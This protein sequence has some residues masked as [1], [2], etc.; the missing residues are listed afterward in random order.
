MTRSGPDSSD[1]PKISEL[2]RGVIDAGTSARRLQVL[3]GDA[4]AHQQFTLIAKGQVKGW[5]KSPGAVDGLARALGIDARAVVL[6]F[7]AELGIEVRESRSLLAAQLPAEA[8]HLS[9]EQTTTI[10]QLVRWI[11]DSESAAASTD[12]PRHHLRRVARPRA[13]DQDEPLQ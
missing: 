7:A 11:A 2:V 1:V 9:V 3:S 10:A 12:A 5:P 4:V 13:D 8:A 6:G